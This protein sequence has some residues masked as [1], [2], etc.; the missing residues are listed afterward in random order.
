MDATHSYCDSRSVQNDDVDDYME[1]GKFAG[2]SW[3]AWPVGL[4]VAHRRVWFI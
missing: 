1:G 2:G 3:N 4:L